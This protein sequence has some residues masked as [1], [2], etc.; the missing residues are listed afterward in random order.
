MCRSPRYQLRPRAVFRR[1]ALGLREPAQWTA[2]YTAPESTDVATRG[3]ERRS[4]PRGLLEIAKTRGPE[5]LS[6]HDAPLC[7]SVSHSEGDQIVETEGRVDGL[8]RHRGQEGGIPSESAV[9]VT[10]EGPGA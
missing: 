6:D 2:G 7:E 4:S 8:V 10:G 1:R 5:V 9:R 3:R